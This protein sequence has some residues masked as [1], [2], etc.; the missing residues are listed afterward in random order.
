VVAGVLNLI[1]GSISILS[2]RRLTGFLS[3]LVLIHLGLSLLGL[4]SQNA[5]A[6]TGVIYHQLGIGLAV[7]A[8]GLLFGGISSRTG[9]QEVGAG[10]GLVD[11][12]PA[13]AAVM[14]LAIGGFLGVP[15][16]GGFVGQSLIVMGSFTAHPTALL[17]VG[18][19][20][21][22]ITY[23][24]FGVFRQLFLGASDRGQERRSGAEAELTSRER[25][26][27][28]PLVVLMMAIGFY[29]KPFLDWVRPTALHLISGQGAVSAE[30]APVAPAVQPLPSPV[31][32]TPEDSD[33]KEE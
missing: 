17:G 7:A 29:P 31:P 2:Q 12:A 4:G 1:V 6:L 25:G 15:G 19:G 5:S 23:S 13:A 14:A 10:G 11:R 24:L 30:P 3:Q 16:L 8:M 33:G 22:L 26:F 20:F 32:E 9:I 21:L 18:A 28:I 27:M